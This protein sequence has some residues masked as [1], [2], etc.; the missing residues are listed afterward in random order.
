MA[1]AT[2]LESVQL[3]GP[4]GLF[5]LR[6]QGGLITTSSVPATKRGKG[7]LALPG[8]CESRPHVFGAVTLAQRPNSVAIA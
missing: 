6:L 5:D 3:I 4:D 1:E 7:L 2:V 8:F